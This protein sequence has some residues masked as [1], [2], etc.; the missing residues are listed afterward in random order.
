MVESSIKKITCDE[1]SKRFGKIKATSSWL[2]YSPPNHR[3]R[4]D[5]DGCNVL[6]IK[7]FG[8]PY[9]TPFFIK[10][11]FLCQNKSNFFPYIK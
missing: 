4:G 11:S 3:L 8:V 9:G 1:T 2:V 5:A 10:E 7:Q 6:L